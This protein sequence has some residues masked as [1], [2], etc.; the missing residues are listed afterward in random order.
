MLEK[1]FEKLELN[2]NER[3]CFYDWFH[4][5]RLN[6]K[7]NQ[8]TSFSRARWLIDYCEMHKAWALYDL[9]L[10]EIVIDYLC[11]RMQA[12]DW[13]EFL[14]NQDSDVLARLCDYDW[15]NELVDEMFTELEE[16]YG[17]E[18]LDRYTIKCLDKWITDNK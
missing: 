12:Q 2:F 16:T 14:E 7:D 3:A 11:N 1:K 10:D 6:I 4:R 17:E 8:W 9:D 18:Q 5:V 15:L 13:Y